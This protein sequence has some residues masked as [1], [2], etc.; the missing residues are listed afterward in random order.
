MREFSN[1]LS[2]SLSE[3]IDKVLTP[4]DDVAGGVDRPVDVDDFG[5]RKAAQ[6]DDFGGAFGAS[7]SEP[8]LPADPLKEKKSKSKR[9][10]GKKSRKDSNEDGFE[11]SSSNPVTLDDDFGGAF[12]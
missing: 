5:S 6:V 12:A 9:Q 2:V 4:T 3:Q 7:S 10:K 11:D 1:D 8:V